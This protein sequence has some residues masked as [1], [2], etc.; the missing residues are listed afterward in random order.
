MRGGPTGDLYVRVHVESHPLFGR[1]GDHLTLRVPITFT[2]AAL[3]A[4]L[5]VPTLDGEPVTLKVPPGTESGKT[6]RVKGR[7][8]PTQSG[9][10]GDLLVTVDVV[11][12]RK[13][14]RTQK[15]L[16][17]QFG[18][19]EDPDELRAHLQAALQGGR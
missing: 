3:G 11:I 4:K 13:L 1:R 6:F 15:K 14:S 16:L 2:E 9:R 18:A 10:Q 7:G 17:D 12:P 19:T 8:V 5:T